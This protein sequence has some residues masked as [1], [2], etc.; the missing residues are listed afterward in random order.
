MFSCIHYDNFNIMLMASH[1]SCS[2]DAFQRNG[3]Y[4]NHSNIWTTIRLT[5][6]VEQERV[7]ESRR[8]NTFWV[9]NLNPNMIMSGCPFYQNV[10]TQFSQPTTTLMNK[11]HYQVDETSLRATDIGQIRH[12]RSVQISFFK[13]YHYKKRPGGHIV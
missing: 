12:H 11:K 6:I 1:T 8:L 3:N 9:T 4:H 7:Q 10:C 5:D 13:H 2:W